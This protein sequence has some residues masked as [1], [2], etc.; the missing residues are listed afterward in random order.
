MTD[1]ERKSLVEKL[2]TTIKMS[3]DSRLRM[4]ET[5][6]AL[7]LTVSPLAADTIRAMCQALFSEGAN[8]AA[9]VI[10]EVVNEYGSKGSGKQ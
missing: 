5:I 3:E 7:G 9:T 2:T 6:D 8:I 4:E 10:Q 1:E